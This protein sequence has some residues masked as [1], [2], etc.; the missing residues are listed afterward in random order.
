M[1][2]CRRSSF[3]GTWSSVA[4]RG[5]YGGPSRD[6]SF[7]LF[8]DTESLERYSKHFFPTPPRYV[9]ASISSPAEWQ[10]LAVLFLLCVY[11]VSFSWR[12]S[13]P[14]SVALQRSISAW[15]KA[16][17]IRHFYPFPPVTLPDLFSKTF[18]EETTI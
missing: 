9:A 17:E 4:S 16:A 11:I 10:F 6:H 14:P 5:L 18:F 13:K 8:F 1:G 3:P 7:L 15:Q 12:Y 2:H